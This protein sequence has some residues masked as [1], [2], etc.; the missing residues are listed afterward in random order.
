M[1]TTLIIYY[2]QISEGYDDRDKFIIMEKVGMTPQEV[3]KSI[4]S[5]ILTIF[6]LPLIVA[7]CH[8]AGAFPL[9]RRILA[10][11]GL[12]NIS[13]F[14]LCILATLL[15]FGIIYALVYSLT[16][17]IYYKIVSR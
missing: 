1:A 14:I 13:L 5:Q 7:G 4:H 10:L 17:K 8:V 11:L 6:F 9:I 15:I 12:T 3:K 16:A 2:K